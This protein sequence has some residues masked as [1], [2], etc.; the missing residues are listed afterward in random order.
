MTHPSNP[1][2]C[3]TSSKDCESIL[4]Q[5]RFASFSAENTARKTLDLTITA[6]SLVTLLTTCLLF[7]EV[8][9]RCSNRT[10]STSFG[11]MAS[12]PSGNS[13]STVLAMSLDTYSKKLLV[14]PPLT[15][16]E[17]ENL[18]TLP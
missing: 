15:T 13:P 3:E 6:C 4:N 9:T 17:A 16:T 12:V 8:K 5:K 2:T 18:N 7:V 14:I 10:Y 11:A 1:K